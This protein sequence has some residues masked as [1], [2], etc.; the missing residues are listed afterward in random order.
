M[1]RKT[2]PFVILSMLLVAGCTKPEASSTASGGTSAPSAAVTSSPEAPAES[3]SGEERS[4]EELLTQRLSGYE[5]T[6]LDGTTFRIADH[7]GKVLLLNAWAT[8]CGPC[9]YEIPELKR[10]HQ[11]YGDEGLVIAGVSIDMA[12]AESAVRQFVK[13][14][15]IGYP[16]L[17]DPQSR[18][19]AALRTTSIPASVMLDREGNVI[20][21]HIGIVSEK[22]D[23]GFREAL[24]KALGS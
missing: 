13:V 18:V 5:A 1:I 17:L 8:W 6:A 22:R 20:W 3:A 11:E 10:L 2:I 12:A 14:N 23:A 21:R 15:D 9:R 24:A 19:T 7:K 4:D 16:I